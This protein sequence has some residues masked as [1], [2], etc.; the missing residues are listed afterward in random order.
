M[1][2]MMVSLHTS[3]YPHLLGHV[4]T[5]SRHCAS[6]RCSWTNSFWALQRWQWGQDGV[7]GHPQLWLGAE[8]AGDAQFL[9][10]PQAVCLQW[11]VKLPH[12][13]YA[14][15]CV[16]LYI[17]AYRVIWKLFKRPPDWVDWSHLAGGVTLGDGWAQPWP[18]GGLWLIQGTLIGSCALFFLSE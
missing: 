13:F 3:Q 16:M 15:S 11:S 17:V 2:Q 9:H 6:P 18:A 7:A 1:Q 12:M 8:G 4:A 10:P 14:L 5:C